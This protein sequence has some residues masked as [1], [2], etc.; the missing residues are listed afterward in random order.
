MTLGTSY[1]RRGLALVIAL[2]ATTAA[3]IP[4][5]AAATDDSVTYMSNPAHTGAQ[6][7]DSL[8]P[9]LHRQWSVDLGGNCCTP[10]MP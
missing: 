4:A 2:L 1:R 5:A 3:G 6:A 10:S 9:P 8:T 7:S